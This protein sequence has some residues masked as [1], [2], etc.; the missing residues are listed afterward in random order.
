MKRTLALGLLA[1]GLLLAGCGG[2]DDNGGEKQSLNLE[3]FT[4]PN[5]NIGC[6]ADENQVRCDIRDKEWPVPP[7]DDCDLDYGNGLS[8]ADGPGE[9][10]CAGDTAMNDGPSLGEGNINMVGPFE[11][12]SIEAGEGIRCENVQTSHGFELS[13]ERFKTY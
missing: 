13:T 11:C 12:E 1:V 4:S 8:V 10:V 3:T 6:I 7:N 9:I 5:G 2:G